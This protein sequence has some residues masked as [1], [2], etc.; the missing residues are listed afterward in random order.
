MEGYRDLARHSCSQ[1]TV[2]LTDIPVAKAQLI[3]RVN[4]FDGGRT[5]AWLSGLAS[6]AKVTWRAIRDAK[7]GHS[8]HVVSDR[9]FDSPSLTSDLRLGLR[10]LNWMTTKT[11]VVWYWWDQPW[12]RLLPANTDPRQEHLNGGWAVPGVPEVHVYRRQEAHKVMIHETIHA[13]GLDVPHALVEPV[14]R[15]FETLFG[16]SLWPH[17]G[18]AFTEFY[19]EWLWSIVQPEAKKA[20]AHQLRCS[21]R[22]A[23]MV[24]TRIRDATADENTNVFAYYVLK[25]VLMQHQESVLLAPSASVAHWY[26]WFLEARPALEAMASDVAWSENSEIPM[27]MTCAS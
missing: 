9:P 16:R 21:E 5:A 24:W 27:G 18:E 15:Q 17:L 20:W 10:L 23:A 4:D 6:G 22:Q 12:D 1:T 2:N 25:W 13:L 7:S 3:G 8:I 14:R 11:A 26:T 19:A